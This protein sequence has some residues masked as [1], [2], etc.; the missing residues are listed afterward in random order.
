MVAVRDR[1]IVIYVITFGII[2]MKKNKKITWTQGLE[3]GFAK[4]GDGIVCILTLGRW[5]AELEL[6]VAVKIGKE[7]HKEKEKHRRN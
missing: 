3:L 7:R 6:G 5:N 4:I 1:R 2:N